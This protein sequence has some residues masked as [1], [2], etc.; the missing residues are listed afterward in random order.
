MR[1]AINTPGTGDGP[2]VGKNLPP[3]DQFPK[4]GPFTTIGLWLVVFSEPLTLITRCWHGDRH[5]NI[6]TLAGMLMGLESAWWS[7]H[8]AGPWPA[9]R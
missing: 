1:A 9:R 4:T 5:I 3:S 6:Y 7:C 2:I 8:T